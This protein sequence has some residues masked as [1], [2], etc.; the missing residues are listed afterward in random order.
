MRQRG[1]EFID[2]GGK[3]EINY[4]SKINKDLNSLSL[5]FLKVLDNESERKTV[6]RK[7]HNTDFGCVLC[8]GMDGIACVLRACIV[9]T[10]MYGTQ[11]GLSKRGKWQRSSSDFHSQKEREEV[12]EKRREKLSSHPKDESSS[13]DV[14]QTAHPFVTAA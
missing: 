2:K 13:I 5:F 6:G 7:G 9:H 1:R 4:S 10:H 3:D 12:Y 11:Q 14:E 8:A